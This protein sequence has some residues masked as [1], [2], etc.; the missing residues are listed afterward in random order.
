VAAGGGPQWQQ[1][2]AA[3]GAGSSSLTALT[4]RSYYEAVAPSS[5]RPD[6]ADSDYPADYLELYR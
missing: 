2:P 5:W 4:S 6:D 3:A 1:C